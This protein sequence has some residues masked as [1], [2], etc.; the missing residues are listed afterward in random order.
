MKQ[1]INWYFLVQ[2]DG[3]E[4]KNMNKIRFS[5]NKNK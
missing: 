1:L 2:F 4:K 5:N 3:E